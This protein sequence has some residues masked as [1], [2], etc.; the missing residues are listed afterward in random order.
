MNRLQF[1]VDIKADK[2]NVWK[3]LWDDKHYRDWGGVF[4]KGSHY[5]IDNWAEGSKIM[6]LA[7]DQSGIY[8]II[9]TYIPNKIIEF[10]HIGSVLNG[11]VQPAN[12]ETKKWSGATE[13][14][15]LIESADFTTLSIEIDVLDEHVEFMSTKF[16]EALEKVKK[17]SR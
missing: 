5:V 6:F 1:S 9:E 8:S 11:K 13:V 17:N 7:P 4:Y 10:R 14:Y 15:S 3:A 12:E 16:P 2:T